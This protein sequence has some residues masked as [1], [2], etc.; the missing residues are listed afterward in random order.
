[1]WTSLA[2]PGLNQAS[3][4]GWDISPLSMHRVLCSSMTTASAV[5]ASTVFADRSRGISNLTWPRNR[6]GLLGPQKIHYSVRYRYVVSLQASL[7]CVQ[8]SDVGRYQRLWASCSSVWRLT[9][10]LT[11][12]DCYSYEKAEA[13]PALVSQLFELHAELYEHG[14]RNF[15]LVDL[16][17]VERS[18]SG[19][20]NSWYAMHLLTSPHARC[21]AQPRKRA[22][23]VRRPSSDDYCVEHGSKSRSREVCSFA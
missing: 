20:S 18:P 19:V 5:I 23:L 12:R 11:L 1:M 16:P 9:S 13:I 14:A 4:T 17:P 22:T 15:M 2:I 10:S 7:E 3:Q 6:A 21:R 8:P